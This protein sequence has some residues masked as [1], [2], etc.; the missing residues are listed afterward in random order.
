MNPKI[1]YILFFFLIT[2]LPFDVHGNTNT[3][4]YCNEL[5]HIAIKES[6]QKS[7]GQSLEL[8]LEMKNI[9]EDN[10]WLDLQANALNYIGVIYMEIL[11]YE[12]AIESFLEAYKVA[13]KGNY[14]Q[15]QLSALHNIASIYFNKND[16]I[17]AKK[18]F[19]Q[20]YQEAKR[21]NDTNNII[22]F[23]INL[24]R[25]ENELGELNNHLQSRWIW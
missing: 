22:A 15:E 8:L 23:A 5:L 6:N 4:E 19:N 24:G 18:Y 11:D 2:F 14:Q 1:V 3:R 20:A 9:A 21:L 16:I 17:T 12:K 7:Y 10:A 13:I 25:I